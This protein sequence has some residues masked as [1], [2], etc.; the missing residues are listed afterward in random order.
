MSETCEIL[1]NVQH[2]SLWYPK[3]MSSFE[4]ETQ[5]ETNSIDYQFSSES[6][7]TPAFARRTI[8]FVTFVQTVSNDDLING[9]RLETITNG[10][11]TTRDNLDSFIE[12]PQH[13]E[14]HDITE[15][16]QSE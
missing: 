10:I 4:S 1:F 5:L 7:A 3:S 13:V 2:V 14:T 15:L 12:L 11:K 8:T 6:F 9:T 16:K